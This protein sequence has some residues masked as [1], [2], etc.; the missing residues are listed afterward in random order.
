M[1]NGGE[2]KF[3][4]VVEQGEKTLVPPA[5]ETEKGLYFLSNFD[6]ILNLENL[7]E[8]LAVFVPTIY[9]F[10]SEDKGNERANEIIKDALSKVL[11][12]YYPL[13]GRLTMSP[14]GRLMV[15]CT[16]E[17][18][19]FVEAEANCRIEDIGDGTK[20]D[21]VTLGKLVYDVSDV[22]SILEVPTLMA[23][24]TK[25]KCG[26]FVLGLCMNHSMFDGIGAMQ[27]VNSWGETAR[28]LPLTIPPFLDRTILKARNPPEIQFPHHEYAEIEDKSDILNLLKQ[29][30]L[31]RSFCFNPEKLENLKSKATEDGA[32]TS[33]TTFEALSAFVWRARSRALNMR[34]DQE[35]RLLFPVD[36]RSRFNPKIPPGYFGNAVVMTSSVCAAGELVENPLSFAVGL[37]KEAVKLVTYDYMRSAIDYTEVN[38]GRPS[39]TGTLMI[40][41]WFRLSFHAM[42]FGW[43][44]PIFSCPATLPEKEVIMFL[45]HGRER[46]SINVL[47]GLPAPAMESFQELMQF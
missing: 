21:P 26:G 30:I 6:Q 19:V 29:E 8:S 22:K 1:E 20:P 43:G 35:T 46:K 47:V 4:L 9:C 10:K 32:I 27:F 24:V 14:D 31:Y 18:A 28:G 7:E 13:A 45:P 38:R 37:V 44:G 25:F 17:G 12:R 3:E 5:E 16:G 2:P 36:S 11:V 34:P 15:D 33:C 23:Q 39:L 40:A 41:V 42:D